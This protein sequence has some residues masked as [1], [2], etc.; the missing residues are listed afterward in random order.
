MDDKLGAAAQAKVRFHQ[1]SAASAKSARLQP[2]QLD[3]PVQQKAKQGEQQASVGRM[4]GGRPAAQLARTT[5]NS[6]RSRGVERRV[7]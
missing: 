4:V 7:E 2:T 5:V 6:F 3:P 1:I